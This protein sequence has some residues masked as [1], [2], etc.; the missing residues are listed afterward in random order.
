MKRW[1]WLG[2]GLV[3]S[4][5]VRAQT[6]F[7]LEEAIRY[8]LTHNAQMQKAQLDIRKA[9]KKVWETTAV[10]LPQLH[11]DANYK[12]FI[13][14]PEQ[15]IPARIFNP[16]AP[17]DAYVP[18][19]FGTEQDMRWQGRITQLIFNGSYIVGLQSARTYKAIS[20]LAAEKTAQKVTEAVT[21]AYMQALL[22]ETHYDILTKDLH[23]VE[24]N[25]QHTLKLYREGFADRSAVDQIKLTLTELK[26]QQ[27]YAWQ[28]ARTARQMLNW[29]MG[30]APDDTL[31]LTDHLEGLWAQADDS[32]V[33]DSDFHVQQHID[34]R[35]A[36]QQLKARKLLWKNEKARALPVIS[37]FASYGKYAYS[38]DFDFF[39]NADIWREQSL[40]G[41]QIQIPLFTSWGRQS[42]IDQARMEYQQALF[43]LWDAE[44]RLNAEY[45]R[46]LNEYRY[47]R[48]NVILRK[49]ALELAGRI[50]GRDGVKYR[51][52]V[53]SPF[54]L[55]QSW[56]QLFSAQQQYLQSIAD[57]MNK[58]IA[59]MNFLGKNIVTP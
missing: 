16:Q 11:L 43:D 8:A 32:A 18:V 56:L 17:A 38:N 24:K 15:L 57:F 26:T 27:N 45:S 1:I 44:H 54:Q 28:M 51:E 39:D 19:K 31:G 2:I 50:A 41:V 3:A 55:H 12:Q 29:V 59:L 20:E 40:V 5:T 42:R 46:L 35:I 37:A 21:A 22:A 9:R 34:Y 10:G 49:E 14:Q 58:K 4:L 30:R 52:G 23:V 47:A 13:K 7:S 36:Q 25:Y 53:L 48:R 33:S 6:S